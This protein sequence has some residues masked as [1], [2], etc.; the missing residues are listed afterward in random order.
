VDDLRIETLT[1]P[2]AT[3]G[4]SPVWMPESGDILW[5]DMP[6][7]RIHFTSLR[8]GGT[9]TVQTPT[10]LGA[11]AAAASGD[12]F[13]AC[14]EGFAWILATGRFTFVWS[15]LSNNERMNDAKCDPVGRLWAGSLDFDFRPG[16]GKLWSIVDGEQPRLRLDGLTQPNGLA[17]SPDAAT[18]YLIDSAERELTAFDFDPISG[19]I[20]HR[21]VIHRFPEGEGYADGMTVDEDGC[22]W[23][24]MWGAGAIVRLAPDGALLDRI[25]VPRALPTSCAFVGDQRDRLV[26]T[27][28]ADAPELREGTSSE[29]GLLLI[30]GLG[31]RGLTSP[32]FG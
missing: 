13:V 29:G 5:V 14:R 22:L 11:V 16:E 26:V 31:T 2:P 32:L 24:A 21:R 7:G 1:A 20:A 17:W 3:I 12:C 10:Y 15:G 19:S 8:T 30:S 25:S 28:A 9:R 6:V 27:S 23:I 18:F 4:E